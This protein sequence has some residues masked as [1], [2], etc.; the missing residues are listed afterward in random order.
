LDA[1]TDHVYISQWK[2]TPTPWT[3]G[4][5]MEF[6]PYSRVRLQMYLRVCDSKNAKGDPRALIASFYDEVCVVGQLRAKCFVAHKDS[7]NDAER[8]K[9]LPDHFIW[10]KFEAIYVKRDPWAVVATANIKNRTL[11]T[12]TRAR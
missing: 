6:L 4:R 7:L 1:C 5:I 8:W 9:K 2:E 3:I 10:A 11:H 12:P